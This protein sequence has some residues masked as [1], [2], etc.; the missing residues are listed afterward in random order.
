MKMTSTVWARL[1]IPIIIICMAGVFLMSATASAKDKGTMEIGLSAHYDIAQGDA[2]DFDPGTSYGIIFHYWLN[3]TST[4][5]LAYDQFAFKAPLETDGSDKDMNYN[6]QALE[7]GWRY[8]PEI[9]LFMKPYVEVGFGYHNWYL[10]PGWSVIDNR[11][12]SSFL[13]FLGLGLSYELRHKMTI[14]ANTRYYY[15]AM[16]ENIETRAT[17]TGPGIYE[18]DKDPLKDVRYLA[19]GIEFTWKIK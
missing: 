3:S 17:E 8:H 4:I 12:G 19:A 7:A 6:I 15:M 14:S 11:E 1:V 2:R 13:Y 16:N 18:I 5:M 10:D 9:D